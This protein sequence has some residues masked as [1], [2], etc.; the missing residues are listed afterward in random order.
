MQKVFIFL[1]SF[2][3]SMGFWQT[4]KEGIL[5]KPLPAEKIKKMVPLL[6]QIR[7]MILPMEQHLKETKK[8]TKKYLVPG[9]LGHSMP[10]PPEYVE[11][12]RSHSNPEFLAFS[13]DGLEFPDQYVKVFNIARKLLHKPHDIREQQVLQLIILIESFCEYERD[14]K[15]IFPLKF[16]YSMHQIQSYPPILAVFENDIRFIRYFRMPA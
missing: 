6:E 11:T 10:V 2:C 13:L 4:F 12:V 8:N 7:D 3:I 5:G 16:K 1:T 14:M 9:V 15:R